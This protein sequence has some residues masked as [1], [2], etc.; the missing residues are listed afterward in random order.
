VGLA[1]FGSGGAYDMNSTA[2]SA[3]NQQSLAQY[4]NIANAYTSTSNTVTLSGLIGGSTSLVYFTAQQALVEAEEK[5]VKAA[6]K[7]AKGILA[8]LRSEID[9]WHGDVLERCPA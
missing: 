2:A 3:A 7:A 4:A 5:V 9:G 8:M 1:Y 6:K